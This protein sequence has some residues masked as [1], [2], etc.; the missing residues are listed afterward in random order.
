MLFGA[1]KAKVLALGNGAG[2]IG[3]EVA[4]TNARTDCVELKLIGDECLHD[5]VMSCL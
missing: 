2:I 5:G 1:E 4:T 3:L